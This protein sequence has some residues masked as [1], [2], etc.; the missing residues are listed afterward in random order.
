MEEEFLTIAMKPTLC[1]ICAVLC[2]E[3]YC[4]YEAVY[5]DEA[6]SMHMMME[7]LVP[8][9]FNAEQMKM[10]E[11]MCWPRKICA[12]CKDKVLGA[13]A[14]YEQCMKS[15]DLLRECMSR[16]T[17]SYI[18]EDVYEDVKQNFVLDSSL[19]LA[20]NYEDDE[21]NEPTQLAQRPTLKRAA[22]KW[23]IVESTQQDISSF[24]IKSDV[25]EDRSPTPTEDYE[26]HTDD[27]DD[28][29]QSHSASTSNKK[30]SRNTSARQRKASKRGSA[31]GKEKP[32]RSQARAKRKVQEPK[33]DVSDETKEP[34]TKVD[35]YRCLLCNAPTYSS[36][37]ELTEHLKTEHP[38]QIHCCAQCPKV[39]MTKAAFEH[40]QYCHA[41]G[42]SHFCMFCDK[43]FQ[44]EQ[45]LKNH[46]RTHTHGTGFLC[47]HCGQ[48]F[49][50]RSNLRQHLIRHTGDKPWQ[51]TLCPSR[52]SMKSY[53]DRHQHTHTKAKYF[54]CDTCGSQFSRHYSLVKHQLIHTGDRY[55][56]C[57]VCNMR[58][59]SSHHVKR[60]MLTHTG[61]KPFKCTYC[62]R[63]FTQSN[64]MVKHM[65]A[66]VGSNPYQC[67][68]CDASFRLLTDL[69]N[70]Y[71]DH[72]QSG[73][74]EA[75][76]G[77]ED[78]NIRFTSTNILKIRYEKEMN[79]SADK[80]IP[81]KLSA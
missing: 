45:L 78:K 21:T 27:E 17:E 53:L 67:D 35:T 18:I 28:E 10:D 25:I 51:C 56:T 20:S 70:H 6:I 11:F 61:E 32:Q 30:G 52:F 41:T 49:S 64:D 40:H 73:N 59:T 77:E 1:R 79:Q 43:G 2:P 75:L 24:N 3:Q 23:H 57:E 8:S 22:R 60:H 42:R 80:S 5:K 58:F 46:I 37:K 15:G 29:Q 38:D 62:E 48:E 7:K 72:Y 74:K 50:N 54:S 81:D 9:V 39:F 33:E 26:L 63:S 76:S 47:S 36:P 31:A 34:E 68:R 55:F 4:I 65:K 44:T 66:H 16:K 69:R 19:E 71:K 13:Y 12:D 14:L